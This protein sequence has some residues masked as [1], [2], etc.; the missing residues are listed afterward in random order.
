MGSSTLGSA[1]AFFAV[2]LVDAEAQPRL[3]VPK[4][5]VALPRIPGWLGK[6]GNS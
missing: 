4:M 2:L 5:G 1:S 3:A 6:G